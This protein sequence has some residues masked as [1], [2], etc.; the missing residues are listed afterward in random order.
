MAKITIPPGVNLSVKW[1]DP[2][3]NSVP[4]PFNDLIDWAA[5]WGIFFKPLPNGG[6]EFSTFSD[7]AQF[8]VAM[9]MQVLSG[10]VAYG[11][12]VVDYTDAYLKVAAANIDDEVPA[13]HNIA[14]SDQ[15]G[16]RTWREMVL[17]RDGGD[18]YWYGPATYPIPGEASGDG[19][20]VG[21]SLLAFSQAPG[22]DIV[23]SADVP[24]VDSGV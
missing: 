24:V 16:S 23:N 4:N 1:L 11:I 20:I 6:S 7:Y 3:T 22:V 17:I 18:G 2:P 15:G 9:L 19:W 5:R 12:E 13:G 8:N 14:D 21:T 10:G